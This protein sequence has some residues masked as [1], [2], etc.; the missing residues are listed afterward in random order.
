MLSL[1]DLLS[2]FLL[3]FMVHGIYLILFVWSINSVAFIIHSGSWRFYVVTEFLKIFCV[4]KKKENRKKL[5]FP[6][7]QKK[8]KN[9]KD[10]RRH[11]FLGRDVE[12]TR[13]RDQRYRAR[14]ISRNHLINIK[15][16]P[17]NHVD[18]LCFVSLSTDLSQSLMIHKEEWCIV[19]GTSVSC[20]KTFLVYMASFFESIHKE[21]V[22]VFSNLRGIVLLG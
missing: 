6:K 22:L 15:R 18:C 13:M 21:K 1:D 7:T 17:K 2:L 20:W 10:G 19:S 12:C 14:N 11:M 8:T 5:H 16:V 3:L 9:R 4:M